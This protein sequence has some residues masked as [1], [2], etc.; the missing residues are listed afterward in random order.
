MSSN[1]DGGAEFLKGLL[2]GGAIG[3]VAALL[4]A[5][6]S[7][8][9]TRDELKRR[10]LELRDDAEAKLQL[11]QKKAEALLDDT[12]KQLDQLRKDAEE[13]VGDLKGTASNVFSEG[14]DTLEKEKNRIKEAIDAGVSAFKDE[15]ASKSSA[16]KKKS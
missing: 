15:K 11:A 7:G 12:K 10:S 13:A 1:G 16:A 2:F 14:L 5:P 4:Y 3:A 9:E 6:K 8:K